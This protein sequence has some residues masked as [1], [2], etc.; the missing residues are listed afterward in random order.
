M[1]R[2]LR[3]IFLLLASPLAVAPFVSFTS[4]VSP[5]YA[6]QYTVERLAERQAASELILVLM[7]LP[8]FVGLPVIL[9]QIRLL[10]GRST[11]GAERLAAWI[12]AGLSAAISLAFFAY[13]AYSRL[14]DLGGWDWHD[15]AV[16][17]VPAVLLA[18]WV[19]LWVICKRRAPA[20]VITTI[21]LYTA[22]LANGRYR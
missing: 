6:V 2:G 17:I 15:L 4:G 22:Y 5:L 18:G 10:F 21:A 9:W 7:A 13:Y 16:S 12:L 1:P 11:T 3:I 8:F 19:L 20:Q 14:R